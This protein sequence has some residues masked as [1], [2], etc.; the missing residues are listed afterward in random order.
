MNNAFTECYVSQVEA[1][2]PSY[3]YDGKFSDFVQ[4]IWVNQ[5][6]TIQLMLGKTYFFQHV[7]PRIRAAHGLL[8]FREMKVDEFLSYARRL[9]KSMEDMPGIL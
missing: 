8:Y 2:F 1:S 5:L 7:S 6:K 3:Q 4:H 9:K